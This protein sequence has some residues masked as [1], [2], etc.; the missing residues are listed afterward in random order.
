MR[1]REK[2]EKFLL[3]FDNISSSMVGEV[4]FK[5]EMLR[6]HLVT[7]SFKMLEASKSCIIL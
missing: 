5:K 7:F 1:E 6:Q 3:T 2:R 4:P